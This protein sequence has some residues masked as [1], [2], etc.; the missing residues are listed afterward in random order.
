MNEQ[1]AYYIGEAVLSN[2]LSMISLFFSF[3]AGLVALT[4]FVSNLIHKREIRLLE[5]QLA[6]QKDQFS[7]FEC[8]VN[9]RVDALKEQAGLVEDI[10]GEVTNEGLKVHR[11]QIMYSKEQREPKTKESS[12]SKF[13]KNTE[14]LSGLITSITRVM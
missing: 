14:A 1:L 3:C 10:V 6:H 4:W 8:I 2:W 12:L 7:Q 11:E 9:Q 5:I 13:L